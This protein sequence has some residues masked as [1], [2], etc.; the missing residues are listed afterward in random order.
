M[1]ITPKMYAVKSSTIAEIGHDES[2]NTLHVKFKGGGHYSYAG[3]P[4]GTFDAL[5]GADSVGKFFHGK[6]KGNFD[7]KKIDP[8]QET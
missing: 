1:P 8:R 7:Y 4:R 6:I 2:A 3:V 5:K